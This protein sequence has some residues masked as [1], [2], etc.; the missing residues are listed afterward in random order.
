[1]KQWVLRS[2]RRASV[3]ARITVPSSADG[4][5]GGDWFSVRCRPRKAST[6]VERR[7]ARV[8]LTPMPKAAGF[9]H[10]VAPALITRLG[11]LAASA[12]ANSPARSRTDGLH[13]RR[14]V[15]PVPDGTGHPVARRVRD[16]GS[17]LNDRATRRLNQQPHYAHGNPLTSLPRFAGLWVS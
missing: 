10:D 5:C 13:K 11:T 15:E 14:D 9:T 6:A 16:W 3:K 7:R 4:A 17:A 2:R 8:L 12:L 1:M